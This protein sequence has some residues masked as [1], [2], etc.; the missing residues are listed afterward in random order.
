MLVFGGFD[1]VL[2]LETLVVPMEG[3]EEGGDG[4]L[5]FVFLDDNA[6]KG[7]RKLLKFFYLLLLKLQPCPHLQISSIFLY[8]FLFYLPL[9]HH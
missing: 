1:Q 5:G 6:L 9:T 3:A 4:E 2:V 8:Q 7:L